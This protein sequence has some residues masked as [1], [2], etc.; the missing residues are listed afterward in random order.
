M[1]K[2]N[3]YFIYLFIILFFFSCSKNNQ[4]KL[5]SNNPDINSNIKE[6][7]I[8]TDTNISQAAVNNKSETIETNIEKKEEKIEQVK[9]TEIK[10]NNKKQNEVIKKVENNKEENKIQQVEKAKELVTFIELGSDRCLPCQMMKPIIEQMKQDY[11]GKVNVLF[12]DVWTPE[13]Q[14]YAIKY[15][16]Y[17][18]PTQIFLD[19][20]GKE[21]FRHTGF[22][23]YEKIKQIF[24][25]VGVK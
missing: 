12:Y 17:A 9:N 24:E 8:N 18:I 13:E 4:N 22:L 5:E 21:F 1:F 10:Q 16:I 2:K 11:A 14:H 19:K 6:N 15:G 25:S 20:D 3:Y 7:T 23:P